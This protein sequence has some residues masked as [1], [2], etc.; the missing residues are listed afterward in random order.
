MSFA[1]SFREAPSAKS[2]RIKRSK[3]TVGSPVSILATRDWLDRTTFA[4]SVWVRF[5]R[6]RR[7]LS[8]SASRSRSSTYASS[9]GDR[10]RKSLVVPIFQPFA[11]SR[12]LLS[13]RIVVLPKATLAYLDYRPRSRGG[14]LAEN[15]ADHDGVCIYP[16]H[17]SPCDTRV[18][19][20]QL[21]A[22]NADYGHGAR[23][24]HR[25][26]MSLLQASK[27][28]PGLQ[29]RFPREGWSLHLAMEPDER[30]VVR[31]HPHIPYVRSD[32]SS[33]E[34]TGQQPPKKQRRGGFAPEPPLPPSATPADRHRYGWAVSSGGVGAQ[35]RKPS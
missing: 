15:F 6:R 9:S 25:E 19:D 31:A 11:S 33:S 22:A 16:V 23:L 27:Q 26:T 5:R 18:D 13:S 1:R 30:L 28:E 20:P 35:P 17:D 29:P 3:E 14:L 4:N 8:P 10:S 21:V 2:D 32:I 34:D 12:V 24:R 7:C